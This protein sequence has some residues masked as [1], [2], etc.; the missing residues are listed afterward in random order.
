MEVISS[1]S[2]R[3]CCCYLI[4]ILLSFKEFNI[5]CDS[6]LASLELNK[7]AREDYFNFLSNSAHRKRL[8][9]LGI[10]KDTEFCLNPNIKSEIIPML[11]E[12]RLVRLN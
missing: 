11:K 12:G 8:K 2:I 6:V 5:N 7:N 9:H 1:S 3:I 10:E 4:D